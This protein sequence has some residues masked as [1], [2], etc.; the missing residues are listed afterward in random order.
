MCYL[1]YKLILL[2]F[3]IILSSYVFALPDQIIVNS[4]NWEDVYS[5]MIYSNLLEVTANY[6]IEETQATLLIQTLNKDKENVLLFESNS[7]PYVR[8]F[9][10]QLNS[11]GFNTDVFS[12]Q[13]NMNLEIL[14]NSEI[15]IENFIVID[16]R[17]SYN[18]VS[19]APYAILTNSYV[20]FA[21]SNNIDLIEDYFLENTPDNIL[22]Y[23]Y[24]D[25]DVTN[26]LNQF[27]PEIINKGSKYENNLEIVK[28]FK[29][30][31]KPTQYILTN[32]LFIEPGFFSKQSPVILIGR[33]NIPDIVFNYLKQSDI[34]NAILIGNDLNDLA[35]SL[36]DNAD[37]KIFIKF[38]KGINQVQYTLDIIELPKLDYDLTISDVMYNL[39][40]SKLYV[41]IENLG[42]A[43]TMFRASFTIENDEETIDNVGDDEI[44]FISPGNSI[45]RVYDIDLEE[46]SNED[47]IV[48]SNILYGEDSRSLDSALLLDKV[49]DF[50]RFT[51]NSNIR[52]IEFY[53]DKSINR[54]FVIV[55]NIGNET[56][57]VN[58]Y[59]E[60]FIFNN[61][62]ENL[63]SKEI[64]RI[65]PKQKEKINIRARLS[66]EDILDNNFVNINLWYGS[67]RN[68]LFNF[69]NTELELKVKSNLIYY[70]IVGVIVCLLLVFF[71]L[72]KRNSK[73]EN[74]NKFMPPPPPTYRN[75]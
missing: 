49:V 53:F 33:N 68:L 25:R 2:L 21:N 9:N 34:K 6:P 24:V 52:V 65:E 60:D 51:D 58:T 40:N 7:M 26:A 62:P 32:G 50:I 35:V 12:Y 72:R 19:I 74:L 27:S 70:V 71:V 64:V 56:V 43:P 17:Y 22:I 39:V 37:M 31:N 59:L 55:E 67:Q 8:N 20:I 18:S 16:S 75:F 48:K 57:F 73:K 45:T 44:S 54:F 5:V 4:R 61:R 63:Y 41:T 1:R 28:K 36:R 13:D 30:I 11:A 14:L 47:L 3:L 10:V 29:E 66:N 69:E 15:D 42:N 38:A 23:G 46:F